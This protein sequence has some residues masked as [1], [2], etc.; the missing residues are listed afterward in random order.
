MG[1][2]PF[3][4]DIGQGRIP[5]E[6]DSLLGGWQDGMG[7]G[8]D[9]ESDAGRRRCGMA[10]LHKKHDGEKTQRLDSLTGALVYGAHKTIVAVVPLS[11]QGRLPLVPSRREGGLK[12]GAFCVVQL[13]EKTEEAAG[14]PWAGKFR[15]SPFCL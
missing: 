3:Y 10:S 2:K 6:K 4:R 14:P 8:C 15:R 5:P 9:R 1:L 13:E 7:T 12:E 11:N